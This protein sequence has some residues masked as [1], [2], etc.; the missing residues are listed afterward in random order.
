MLP[1]P[2]EINRSFGVFGAMSCMKGTEFTRYFSD[3]GMMLRMAALFADQTLNALKVREKVEAVRLSPRER[4]CLLWLSK[5]LRNDRIA[6]RMGISP[7]TVEMH[8]AKARKKL[9]A[10]TREQALARA[11]FLGLVVP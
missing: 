6:E 11:I 8:L 2:Y 5:G 4:E 7:A 3:R 1:L 10:A 9:T